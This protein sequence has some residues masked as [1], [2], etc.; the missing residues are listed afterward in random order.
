LSATAPIS[1]RA[2]HGSRDR[3]R[4]RDR[5]TTAAIVAAK[6]VIGAEIGCD[7]ILRAIPGN[8]MEVLVDNRKLHGRSLKESSAVGDSARGV[9]LRALTRMGREVPLSPD[10]RI[11]VATS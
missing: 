11:Y 4:R 5:R 3:R 1:S 7:E 9:F 8:V 6:P 10:T 2:R